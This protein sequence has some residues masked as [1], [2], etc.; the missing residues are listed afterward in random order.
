[1]AI[2]PILERIRI[3]IFKIFFVQKSAEGRGAGDEWLVDITNDTPI[4]IQVSNDNGTTIVVD[5]AFDTLSIIEYTLD[6]DSVTPTWYS[7]NEGV[8][9]PALA[10]QSRYI[11]VFNG[12]VINFRAQQAG[13]L[14]YVIVGAV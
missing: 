1:M 3:N 7:F 6:G 5:F 8:A 10:G 14:E 9:I 12:A 2:E 13:N 11:R 4:Q